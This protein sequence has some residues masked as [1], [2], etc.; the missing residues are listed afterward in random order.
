MLNVGGREKL[1]SVG[2]VSGFETVMNGTMSCRA[3]FGGSMAYFAP[4]IASAI[5]AIHQQSKAK[6]SLDGTGRTKHNHEA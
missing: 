2:S 6:S 5:F 3:I 4:I 1:Q